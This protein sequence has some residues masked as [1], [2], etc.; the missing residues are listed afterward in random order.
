MLHA[1][2]TLAREPLVHFLLVGAGVYGLYGFAADGEPPTDERT[3]M[4]RAS[5]I[6]ALS[7]QWTRRWGRAPTQGEMAGVIRDQVR[8]RILYREAV[9][10]GLDDGDT[11]IERRLAQKVEMLA[12]GLATPPEPAPEVLEAWFRKH[13]DRFERPSLYTITHIFFDPDRRGE[14][15]LED[16]SRALAELEALPEVPIDVGGYGDRFMLQNY[17]PDRSERELRKLFGTGFVDH[18]LTLEPGRW[19]GPILSGFGTHLVLVNSVIEAEAPSFSSVEEQVKEEWISEQI[20]ALGEQ[21]I[22]DLIAR[23]E[24]VV[25][26]TEVPLLAAGTAAE[27][28][29]AAP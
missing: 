11:V 22:D 21:F 20:D 19:H 1:L 10:M 27:T 18:V 24:V 23:Y 17:Y 16:A 29:G 13:I 26:E 8:T 2:K 15:T 4:I 7:E 14:A 6:R 3:V 12:R 5:E 28:Q 25:E 9:A